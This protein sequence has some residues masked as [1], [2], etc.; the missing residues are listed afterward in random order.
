[1]NTASAV[2]ST[3]NARSAASAAIVFLRT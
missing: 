2:K 3:T 1:V